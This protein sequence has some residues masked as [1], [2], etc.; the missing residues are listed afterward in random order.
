MP[1]E[2]DRR[3][4]RWRVYRTLDS[5]IGHGRLATV[6]NLALMA[7]IVLNVIAVALETVQPLYARWGWWLDLFEAFCVTVFVVE[8]VARVWSCVEN[9]VLARF[10]DARARA[11]FATRPMQ[12]IDFLAIAPSLLTFLIPVD[13]T[14]LRLLRLFRFFKIARYSPAIHSLSRVVINE[15]GSLFGALL[16]IIC[17][18]LFSATALYYVE[19]HVQP[20]KFGSIPES[21]W[22]AV[23]TLATVGYGDVI[24]VTAAGKLMTGILIIVGMIVFALPVGIIATGFS[25]EVARR[26]FVVTWTLVARV[27]L[28]SKLDASAIA[29]IMTLLYSRTLSSGVEIIQAGET[30]ETLY[31]ITSGEVRV[32]TEAGPVVLGEGEFFGEMAILDERRHEHNVTT[33]QRTR[34]LVLEREDFDRLCRRHKGILEHVKEVAA[35]RIAVMEGRVPAKS[36]A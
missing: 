2:Q 1:D 9:P 19:R 5:T 32:D 18:L 21:L 3:G 20:D 12:L 27:P 11:H 31:F 26:D 6:V 22:W 36:D 15:R 29:E 35:E 14:A 28:F 4:L 10:G 34:L 13:L 24:P 23:V 25:Q 33:T 7:L 30:D 17:L 16:V 8:Y